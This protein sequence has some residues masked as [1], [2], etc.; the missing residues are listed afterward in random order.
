M[1]HSENTGNGIS[2]RQLALLKAQ[3]MQNKSYYTNTV[4]N[5]NNLNSYS[6]WKLKEII[7]SEHHPK[8]YLIQLMLIVNHLSIS[9]H[10]S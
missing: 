8:Q 10:G 6:Y 3:I 5:A 7:P 4:F 9:M 2:C 1:N